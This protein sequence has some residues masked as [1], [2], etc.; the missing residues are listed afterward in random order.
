[1]GTFQKSDTIANGQLALYESTIG[2]SPIFR[3]RNGTKPANCA[4]SRAGTILASA[5]LPS[6]WMANPS[7][8]V[9]AKTGTWEDTAADNSGWATHWEIMDSTGT[10]CHLQGLVSQA[11]QASTAYVLNQQVNINSRVYKCTTA[12]TSASSGGPS[13][14]GTGISDGSCVW[15]YVGPESMVMTNTNIASGQDVLVSTFGITAGNA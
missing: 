3:L 6:D 5:T 15:D 8:R 10:T 14:T 13:G 11:W 2:T 9:V 4:A 1:M 7:S 12:G